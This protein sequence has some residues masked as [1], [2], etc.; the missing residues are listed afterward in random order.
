HVFH[1]YTLI[2]ENGDQSESFRDNLVA[3]LAEN[4]IPSMIY[5]PVPAHKQN[6]FASFGGAD[7]HLEKTDWLTRR[8]IS[9]PIHTEMVEEQ[10]NY[11]TGKVLEY[12]NK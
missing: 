2:I 3:F 6:M 9:L 12:V 10:L 4:N 1:Q 8:V 5:Y 7:Y 11:I